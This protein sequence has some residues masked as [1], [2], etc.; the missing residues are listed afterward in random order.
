MLGED[1]LEGVPQVRERLQR[2]PGVFARRASC[3][4]DGPRDV[5]NQ[6]GIVSYQIG[7][8]RQPGK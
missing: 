3:I 5:A 8:A 2:L 7:I 6:A 4:L 1:L